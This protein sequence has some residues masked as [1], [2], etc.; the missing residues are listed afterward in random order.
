MRY[1]FEV[2][3]SAYARLGNK[4]RT[5]CSKQK[6]GIGKLDNQRP[7]LECVGKT[8]L[9][10]YIGLKNSLLGALKVYFVSTNP[11]TVNKIFFSLKRVRKKIFAGKPAVDWLVEPKSFPVKPQ[12]GKKY[13]TIKYFFMLI[14]LIVVNIECFG[15]NPYKFY[16]LNVKCARCLTIWL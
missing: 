12:K 11:S 9:S 6:L 14:F 13:L 4:K 16:P 8:T 1:F 3:R 7:D 10:I 15:A 2:N 5:F